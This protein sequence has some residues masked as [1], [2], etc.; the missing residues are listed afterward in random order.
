MI[1]NYLAKFN[2]WFENHSLRE[3]IFICI[4]SWALIYAAF[5]LI[6]FRPIDQSSSQTSEAIKV[7]NDKIKNW[8]NQIKL[9]KEIPN[10]PLYKEWNVHHQNYLN[11]KAKYRKLL[12]DPNEK[13]WENILKTV[14]SDYPNILIAS[15]HHTPETSYETNKIASTPE[16]I[17]QQQLSLT[18]EGNFTD[19]VGYLHYLE[20]TLP[21]IHWNT[22]TYEVKDYPNAEVKMELSVL[23]EKPAS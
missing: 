5:S 14:L 4:L 17:Y 18:V 15:I 23:Y 20:G 7:T 8:Q 6:L 11:L 1:N 21:N 22:L 12:G 19:I 10:T 16:E 9:I 3:K 13:N 2:D